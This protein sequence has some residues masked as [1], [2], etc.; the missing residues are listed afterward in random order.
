MALPAYE[1]FPPPPGYEPVSHPNR[2]M[3]WGGG[4]TFVVAYGAAIAFGAGNGFEEG[5]GLTALPLLGPWLAIGER[6]FTCQI[7]ASTSSAEECQQQTVTEAANVAIL[8]G[9]GIGQLVGATLFAVGFLDR[10]HYW[11]RSDLLSLDFDAVATPTETR[12]MIRGIF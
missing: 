2:V 3:I 9:L 6:D 4:A 7:R 5:M 10:Q 1:G 12:L 8:A 11:V